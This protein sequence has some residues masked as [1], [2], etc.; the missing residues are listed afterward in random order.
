MS[1][2]AIF[3]QVFNQAFVGDV[4]GQFTNALRRETCSQK[5][6]WERLFGSSVHDC[7]D[8]AQFA[9]AHAGE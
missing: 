3:D 1:Q 2:A 6:I 8:E 9:R 5:T 4:A 7:V